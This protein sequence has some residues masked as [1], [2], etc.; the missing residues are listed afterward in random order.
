LWC[1]LPALPTPKRFKKTSGRFASNASTFFKNAVF[2]F[3]KTAV[4]KKKDGVLWEQ[5]IW[6][7]GK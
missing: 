3:Q 5:R 1:N 7:V 6:G 2:F 4:C